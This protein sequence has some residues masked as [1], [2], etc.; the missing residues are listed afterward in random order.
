MPKESLTLNGFLGG[1]NLE[2]AESDIV[3]EGQGQD[4]CVNAKNLSLERKG[5]IRKST[6]LPFSGGTAHGENTTTATKALIWDDKFY[7]NEAVYKVGEDINWNGKM[8]LLQ[9]NL[10]LEI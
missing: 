4:E 7:Q 1:L 6:V 9:L 3:S 5:K 2:A 10:L 8:T